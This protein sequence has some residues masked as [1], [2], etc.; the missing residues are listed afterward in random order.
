MPRE[1]AETPD[2]YILVSWKIGHEQLVLLYIC[3]LPTTNRTMITR[4]TLS[5][6][7]STRLVTFGLLQHYEITKSTFATCMFSPIPTATRCLDK[8]HKQQDVK[9]VVSWKIGGELFLSL[10]VRVS[11]RNNAKSCYICNVH[12]F[13]HLICFGSGVTYATPKTA[14]SGSLRLRKLHKQLDA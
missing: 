10:Y 2:V 11:L 14:S 8:L 3:N 9:I 5:C 1:A 12:V 4:V 6:I 7:G 13:P